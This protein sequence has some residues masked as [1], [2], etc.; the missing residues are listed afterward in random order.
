MGTG[1][2]LALLGWR[3]IV[4]CTALVPRRPLYEGWMS[5][6]LR[7]RIRGAFCL[8]R[9]GRANMIAMPCPAVP[10]CS[11][12]KGTRLAHIAVICKIFSIDHSCAP[13]IPHYHNIFQQDMVLYKLRSNS[14][15]KKKKYHRLLLPRR[16][17][18]KYHC[19]NKPL[20]CGKNLIQRNIPAVHHIISVPQPAGPIRGYCCERRAPIFEQRGINAGP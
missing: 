17:R 5:R 9:Y 11:S 15:Q 2:F 1:L 13:P 18:L 6:H 7:L 19:G 12:P 14:H 3:P 4:D 20:R 8:G 10:L 16:I